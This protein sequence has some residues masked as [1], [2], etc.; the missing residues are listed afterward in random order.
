[1][2][3]CQQSTTK[4]LGKYVPIPLEVRTLSRTPQYIV[5]FNSRIHKKFYTK[6]EYETFIE[7]HIIMRRRHFNHV[8]VKGI[9]YI[10]YIP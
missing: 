7:I 6:A 10:D 4:L 1:M 8:N 2:Y 3:L 5:V 9:A